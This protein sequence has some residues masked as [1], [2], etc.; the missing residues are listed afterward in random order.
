MQEKSSVEDVHSVVLHYLSICVSGKVN[1]MDHVASHESPLHPGDKNCPGVCLLTSANIAQRSKPNDPFKS[2]IV[3]R[4]ERTHNKRTL[5]SELA[6]RSTFVNDR[7]HI[8]TH[9]CS[10]PTQN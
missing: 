10:E 1:D 3:A 5:V 4:S 6:P 7:C 2:R 8:D 9:S